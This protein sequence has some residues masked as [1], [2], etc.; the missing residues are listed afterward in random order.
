MDSALL[1]PLGCVLI[2]IAC[3]ALFDVACIHTLRQ[4]HR[5]W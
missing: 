4:Q 2:L 5:R 1:L 3:L